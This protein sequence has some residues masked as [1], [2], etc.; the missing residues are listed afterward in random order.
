MEGLG[1]TLKGGTTLKGAF[2]RR[3]Y[4]FSACEG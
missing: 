2:Q 1:A 3:R 4:A